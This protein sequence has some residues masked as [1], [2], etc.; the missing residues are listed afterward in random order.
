MEYSTAMRSRIQTLRFCVI[1]ILISAFLQIILQPAV[2]VAATFNNVLTIYENKTHKKLTDTHVLYFYPDRAMSDSPMNVTVILRYLN[3]SNAV[4]KWI[5]IYDVSVH[6]RT[7]V[8][9]PNIFNSTTDRPYPSNPFRLMPA[10][11]QYYHIFHI[12]P[13]TPGEYFVLLSYNATLGPP[14]N[15]TSSYDERTEVYPA[16]LSQLNIVKK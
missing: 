14:Y 6:L 11:E 5:D 3:D 8:K 2:V 12:T 9:G 4:S 13:T 15:F 1:S 16:A 7:S 10:G